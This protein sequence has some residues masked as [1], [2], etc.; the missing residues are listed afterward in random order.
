M[1]PYQNFTVTV[2]SSFAAGQAQVNVAHTTLIGVSNTGLL[3]T[4]FTV[5]TFY[6]RLAR[7]PIWTLSTRLLSFPK[8]TFSFSPIRV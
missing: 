1:P 7:T 6:I 3:I 2:P 8:D 4:A 5:L